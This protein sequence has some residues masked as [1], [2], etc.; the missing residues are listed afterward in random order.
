MNKEIKEA[1][2]SIEDKF[3]NVPGNM[4]IVATGTPMIEVYRI[5]SDLLKK[6]DEQVLEKC[7][8]VAWAGD[9]ILCKILRY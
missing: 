2:Y 3:N 8:K 4:P 9:D 5:V 6:R 1:L 7:G